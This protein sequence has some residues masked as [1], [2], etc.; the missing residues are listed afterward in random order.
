MNVSN[1]SREKRAWIRQRK[2]T[3]N[4]SGAVKDLSPQQI[5]PNNFAIFHEYPSHEIAKGWRDCLSRVRLPAGYESPEF[6]LESQWAGKRPFAV[7][8]LNGSS[9]VGILTGLH[10]GNQVISG[11]QSRPQICVDTAADIG[12]TLA[13]LARGLLAEAGTA[14]LVTAFSWRWMPLSAFELYGFRSRELEGNVVIDLN[15]GP[16]ALFKELNKKRRT[17][18]RSAIRNGIEVFQATTLEEAAL[19]HSIY[20]TWRTTT[21]IRVKGEKLP[22][23][24]FK[25][26]FHLRDTFRF[27]LARYSGKVIAGIT[28]RFSSRGLV[29]YANNS[30][31]DE[32]LPL[33]PNDLLVWKAIEWACGEGFSQFSLG[34]A[35]RFLREFGGSVVPICRYR[36]DRSSL[37]LYDRREAAGDMARRGFRKLPRP[38]RKVV[39]RLLG[40]A[41]PT[42]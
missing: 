6:F 8:A 36:L 32:F 31:L 41:V 35:H 40:K 2:T 19:F 38:L 26:R 9:I 20:T 42:A 16:D 27:F 37:H 30:S 21:R 7:A 3:A 12:A 5:E 18:I 1:N 13:S 10:E 25:Q 29:E 28:L 22:W 34:G 4:V 39:H 11:L 23:A 17:N 15:K 33:R 14:K 24:V